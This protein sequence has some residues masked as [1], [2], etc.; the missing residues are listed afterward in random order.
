MVIKLDHEKACNRMEWSF[1]EDTLTDASFPSNL[2]NI[3]MKCISGGFCRL[4]WNGK[5]TH[6]TQP[7][8]GLRQSDPLSS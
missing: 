5:A 6:S 2:I 8:L 3:I 4:L 7:S 1:I